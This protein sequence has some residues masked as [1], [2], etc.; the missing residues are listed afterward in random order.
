MV[1]RATKEAL[2]ARSSRPLGFATRHGFMGIGPEV[3][4]QGDVIALLFGGKVHLCCIHK[5][6]IIFSLGIVMFMI[7]WVLNWS[8]FTSLRARIWGD[9]C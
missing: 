3:V 2:S 4:K 6:I 7:S 1:H 8:T 5:A 9:Q